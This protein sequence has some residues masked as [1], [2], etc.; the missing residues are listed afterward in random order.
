MDM[1]H[2]PDERLAALYDSPPTSAELAHLASCERCA[3]ERAAYRTLRE[4]ANAEQR[5]GA[6]LSDWDTL[7]P[8]LRADGVI[9]TG[10]WR[11]ARRPRR[12]SGVWSQAAAALL[13]ALGGI[14][15]GRYSTVGSVLPDSRQRAVA[16]AAAGDSVTFNSVD[17]AR[18]AQELYQSLY[19]SAALYLAAHDTVDL[20]PGSPAAIRRRLAA[21]DEVGATVRQ[22]LTESPADP[23]INGYY[24]TTLGQREATLRQLNASL[25]VGVR[26]N[27]F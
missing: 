10:E 3:A 14:A 7:A 4:L 1:S 13:I 6:P 20:A 17:E 27:S 9:D 5:I 21:L 16:V 8:A 15:Y 23:V 25:P 11:V 26:L 12:F 24:L 19:Q 18:Q 2:L 22:A